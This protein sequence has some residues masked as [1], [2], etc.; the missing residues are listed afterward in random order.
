MI[1]VTK[2]INHISA[3]A[4]SGGPDSMAAHHFIWRHRPQVTAIYFN[5]GTEHGEDA[6]HFLKNYC[7]LKIDLII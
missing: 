6:E 5:H 2:S 7:T 3:V 4:L 1:T